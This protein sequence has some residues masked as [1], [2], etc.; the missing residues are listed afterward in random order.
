MESGRT[1]ARPASSDPAARRDVT[2][3]GGAARD[4][5]VAE[6]DHA[7]RALEADRARGDLVLAATE[8]ELRVQ[9]RRV[10]H[11][12]VVLERERAADAAETAFEELCAGEL[13]RARRM[14]P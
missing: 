11:L 6:R 2:L 10:A 4:G 5:I 1:C 12:R 14:E 7:G 9:R 13:D 8:H 3:V